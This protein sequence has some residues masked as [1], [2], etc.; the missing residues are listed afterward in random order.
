MRTRSALDLRAP[1]HLGPID[2]SAAYNF[3]RR[4]LSSFDRSSAKTHVHGGRRIGHLS[5]QRERCSAHY[6][7]EGTGCDRTKEGFAM[8]KRDRLNGAPSPHL[9]QRPGYR[10]WSDSSLKLRSARPPHAAMPGPLAGHTAQP[11]CD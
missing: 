5:C 11:E 3:C 7:K 4:L 6:S 9:S 10:S 2:L 1:G 8:R